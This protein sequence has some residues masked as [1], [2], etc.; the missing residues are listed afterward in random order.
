M[1]G[2]ALLYYPLIFFSLFICVSMGQQILILV[3]GLKPIT[4]S[5]HFCMLKFSRIW[6][7]GTPSSQSSVLSTAVPYFLALK[8]IPG[9]SCVFPSPS[10]VSATFPRNL[11]FVCLFA[12]RLVYRNQDE[13]QTHCS[14][15][16]LPLYSLCL[17]LGNR[18]MYKQACI[19]I[20]VYISTALHL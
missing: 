8:D 4:I 16:S 13:R 2:I 1:E 11:F 10:L 14:R 19:Y 6:P 17:E 7:L 20:H 9:S 3:N 5:L 18:Y 12:C 15:A